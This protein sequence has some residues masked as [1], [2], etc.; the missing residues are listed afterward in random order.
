MYFED[1]TSYT[2]FTQNRLSRAYNIGWVEEDSQLKTGIIDPQV[3]LL[4]A[5]YYADLVGNQTRGH[6]GCPLCGNWEPWFECQDQRIILG[7]AELWIPS[8]DD[9][10]FITPD[11]VIHYL[12]E[13]SYSPPAE[14]VTAVLRLPSTIIGWNG[15]AVADRLCRS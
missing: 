3:P 9:K 1:L 11:L 14:F 12:R 7:A 5:R 4:L 8:D 2:Y 15:E 13:H 10:I 6:H